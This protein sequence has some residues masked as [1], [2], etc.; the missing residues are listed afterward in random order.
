MSGIAAPLSRSVVVR[1]RPARIPSLFRA[2]A[3]L[4]ALGQWRQGR[5]LARFESAVSARLEHAEVAAVSSGR[6]ALLLVL[7]ALGVRP[8]D[9]ILLASYNASCVPN[10]L[11][12]AGYRLHFLDVD[13]DRLT[14]TRETL[15]AAS[16]PDDAPVLIATHMEGCPAPALELL[17]WVNKRGCWLVEDAAHALG[18]S[19]KGRP[20]GAIGHGAIFSLGRGKHLNTMGGGLGVIRADLGDARQRLR[21]LADGLQPPPSAQL[22]K[23][24]TM[25]SAVRVGT[26][27]GVFSALAAPVMRLAR[28]IDGFDPMAT[29]FEDDKEAWTAVPAALRTR[30]SN[31]QAA[32]GNASLERFDATLARR[33][34]H[35][36]R[37]RA[38]LAEVPGLRLQ[39]P[40]PDTRSAWL[41][42]TAMVRDRD[43]FQ[44]RMLGLGVD[45]QRTWMDACDHL[46]AFGKAGGDVCSV[47]RETGEQA[48][49]LPTYAALSDADVDRVIAAVR[50]AMA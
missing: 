29:L 46:P 38:E 24:L 44:R 28:R 16:V 26:H 30:L 22:A 34:G 8:P 3:R 10:V 14:V 13:P 12:A 21:E 25:D 40:G 27:P 4:G 47:S 17:D 1:K 5:E 42:L 7:E 6:F 48:V 33:R 31:L 19:E 20:V 23:E 32:F 18:A 11:Q 35:A 43:A 15:E 9:R 49:Y 45:T 36:E 2:A 50:E 41:E 37:M 39:Q